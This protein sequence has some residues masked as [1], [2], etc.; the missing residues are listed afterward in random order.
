MTPLE[1]LKNMTLTMEVLLHG[2]LREVNCDQGTAELHNYGA[3]AIALRFEAGWNETMRQLATRYV[4]VRGSGRY[5]ANDER[6]T[7]TVR[8]VV[9][10][11]SAIDDLRAREPK[12]FDPDKATV[13]YQHDAGDPIDIAKFIRVIYEERDL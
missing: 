6:E 12:I 5:N 1:F 11:R 2:R 10:E 8:E 13:F 3:P 4:K 7:V 9:A